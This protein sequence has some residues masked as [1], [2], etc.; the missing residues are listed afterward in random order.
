VGDEIGSEST[1]GGFQTAALH[2]KQHLWRDIAWAR[3]EKNV[4]AIVLG[5]A[6]G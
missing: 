2:G 5:S 3:S 4:E 1:L 6:S